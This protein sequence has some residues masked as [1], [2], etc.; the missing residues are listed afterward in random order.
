[1][2][3]LS[4]MAGSFGTLTRTCVRITSYRDSRYQ[5]ACA[6]HIVV[7]LLYNATMNILSTVSQALLL[8]QPFV[9]CL[10]EEHLTNIHAEASSAVIGISMLYRFTS[11][12]MS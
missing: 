6:H 9:G 7:N 4:P 10:V 1:M 5:W 8:N 2:H 3:G 11:Q 12:H